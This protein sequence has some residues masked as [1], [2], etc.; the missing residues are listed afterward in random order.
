MPRVI[1]DEAAEHAVIGSI[2]IDATT[3]P[4]Y[5]ESALAL[6]K[7][8]LTPADFRDQGCR[9][10][11]EAMLDADANGRRVDVV[12]LGPSLARRGFFDAEAGREL[13]TRIADPDVTPSAA[14]ITLYVEQV[15]EASARR[16]L[17]LAG[18]EMQALAD[19]PSEAVAD[20]LAKA[21][22]GLAEAKRVA[23]ADGDDFDIGEITRAIRDRLAGID[24]GRRR[25]R[26][27][28]EAID[29]HFGGI[30][31]GEHWVIGGRS[32][33]MKTALATNVLWA[34]LESGQPAAMF[35]FEESRERMLLRLASLNSGVPYGGVDAGN[36]TPDDVDAFD[37][38]LVSMAE[39]Y[40]GLLEV[41]MGMSLAHIEGTIARLK[42][43]LVVID[44]LQAAADQIGR[45]HKDRRD[46]EIQSICQSVARLCTQPGLE[47]A[48][49]VVSQLQK[50]TGQ[51]SMRDL[52]ESGSI[53]ES[54]DA[55]ILLWWPRKER[56]D[57]DAD[58]VVLRV[59]KNRITG[60]PGLA[61]CEVDPG[62]QR[63]GR[64]IPKD[65]A[66]MFLEA[67]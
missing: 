24:G 64:L 40:R 17:A 51:P 21:E 46:L 2:L 4:P 49:I 6:A 26:T 5:R 16:R 48:A 50:G 45:R 29:R 57:V 58:K 25:W 28:V 22:S 52:R 10:I 34:T 33:H 35:R 62:T 32:G 9:S 8:R 63:F 61:V 11:F 55:V 67:L 38:A 3:D 43:A 1:A 30:G 56:D 65:A 59:G 54:A 12:T 23:T 19:D 13:L 66:E 31:L 37:A 60:P 14:N 15:A 39:R 20:V 41:H 42:P 18:R 36:L 27:G 7:R 53:E 44:T 47:H